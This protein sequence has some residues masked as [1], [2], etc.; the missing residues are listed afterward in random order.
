ML[1]EQILQADGSAAKFQVAENWLRTRFDSNKTPP[2]ELLDFIKKLQDEPLAHLPKIM[3]T[4]PHTQK[5]LIDQFKKYVG[6][7]PKYYQRILRFNE[8]L[9]QIQH[10]NNITWSQIAY[11]YGYSD[12][13][14][15]IKEFKH[16][17]GF[18][19][20]EFIQKDLN[21]GEVNFFTLDGE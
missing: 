2:A 6:L 3:E 20:Q 12:Q 8:I 4:Y 10:N 1:R 16:F 17:S 14:H 13:S 21:Q 9:L 11:Q 18:N 5:H 7:T 15:F 19:P